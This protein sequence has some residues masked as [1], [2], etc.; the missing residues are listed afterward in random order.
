MADS[1]N[2]TKKTCFVV[3]PVTT[4]EGYVE[5]SGDQAHFSHVLDYLFAPALRSVGYEVIPPSMLGSDIIQAEIIKNLEQAD[6]VLCDMSSLNPNVFFELG[7]RTALD[8][9]VVLVRDS[10]TPKLPFDIN[11]INTH[12]YEVSLDPWVL[13]V[14]IPRLADHIKAATKD[15]S[16]IGNS[17]WRYFGLTKRASPSEAADNPLEAKIDI[18]LAELEK[19]QM[20]AGIRIL[21]DLDPRAIRST[22]PSRS[23]AS[24]PLIN[25]ITETIHE[26]ILVAGLDNLDHSISYL[27]TSRIFLVQARTRIPDEVRENIKMRIPSGTTVIFGNA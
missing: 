9:P 1:V 13:S 3:M 5:G 12:T 14:E 7:I 22:S 17:M 18:I 25:G 20:A 16:K 26:T 11:A 23:D 15:A 4:P 6:L 10:A 24:L 21:G 27:P 2:Q 19:S 8:R